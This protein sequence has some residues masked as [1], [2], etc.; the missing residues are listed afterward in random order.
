MSR[1]D[2]KWLGGLTLI[3]HAER[4]SLRHMG[5]DGRRHGYT[6]LYVTVSSTLQRGIR[7]RSRLATKRLQKSRTVG[8]INGDS[9]D[10]KLDMDHHTSS[11][12][13]NPRNLQQIWRKFSVLVRPAPRYRGRRNDVGRRQTPGARGSQSGWCM[14]NDSR[15]GAR[16]LLKRI[17]R[18]RTQTDVCSSTDP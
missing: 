7:S 17:S 4:G 15:R 3:P 1:S 6:L 12:T 13:E 18:T 14:W 2:R 8:F 16:P 10:F 11:V 5:R 9:I